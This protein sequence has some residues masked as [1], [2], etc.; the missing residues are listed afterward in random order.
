MMPRALRN[1]LIIALVATIA[2]AIIFRV[3]RIKKVVVG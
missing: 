1:Y 2:V 3:E